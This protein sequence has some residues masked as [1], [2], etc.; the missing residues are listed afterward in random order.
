[1][2]FIAITNYKMHSTRC[3]GKHHREFFEGKTLVDIKIEQLQKA[4]AEHIYISTN[5]HNVSNTENI[6]YIKR[7]EKYCDEKLTPF[8]EVMQEIYD[9][10]PVGNDVNAIFTFTM[11]PL[12]DRYAQMYKQYE[13]TGRNQLAVYPSRH[14]YLDVNKRGANFMF[15][16]W[17]PYSQGIDPMYQLPY[18]GVLATMGDHRKAGYTVPLDFDY[19]EIETFENLDIDTEEEF[20]VGQ[21]LYRWKTKKQI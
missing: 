1:M 18:C 9:S 16:A 6:T 2:S 21:M 20:E 13:S 14:Y 8:N 11:C 5:D 7:P 10:I 15:G 19:F 4:G 3:P 17:H 12:F